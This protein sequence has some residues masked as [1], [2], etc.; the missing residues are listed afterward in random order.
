[1]ASFSIYTW[2]P[3]SSC[4]SPG[5][6]WNIEWSCSGKVP[7]SFFQA[8]LFVG[9]MSDQIVTA[10]GP[11]E[12][13]NI[14]TETRYHGP[15]WPLINCAVKSREVV[16]SHQFDQEEPGLCCVWEDVAFIIVDLTFHGH[17]MPLASFSSSTPATMQWWF[18]CFGSHRSLANRTTVEVV[19]AR[20]Q[21]CSSFGPCETRSLQYNHEREATFHGSHDPKNR[22]W[23]GKKRTRKVAGSHQFA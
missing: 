5:R 11:C 4:Q 13:F 6:H 3:A 21:N 14:G 19:V 9:P 16:G 2:D 1:M 12:N 23:G 10:R 22:L 18:V 15:K 20:S 8:L 7:K 17:W